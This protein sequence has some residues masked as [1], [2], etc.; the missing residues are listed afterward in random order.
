[1]QTRT[2]LQ[3]FLAGEWPAARKYP[4]LDRVLLAIAEGGIRINAEVRVAGLHDIRGAT[5]ETNVQGEIVQKLDALG[6][7][8]FVDVLRTC[9]R[10]AA[11]ACE[12]I[13][14]A[15]IVSDGPDAQ[16][17]AVFD[18]IDGS[19]NIDVAV[20]IGSIFGIYQRS[21]DVSAEALLRPGREQIC[22]LYIVYGSSTILALAAEGEVDAFTLDEH[23]GE[24]VLTDRNMKLP[25]ECPYYSV[26]EGNFD[27]W[28]PE[29]RE[30]VAELRSQYSLRYVGSL[31]SDF[32]RTLLKGGVFLY[33]ADKKSPDGKLRLLYEANPMAFLIE[34]AG[35]AAS[36]G[37]QRIMDIE[38]T[39][40]H[41]RTPLII[42][43]TEAVRLV[44]RH[45]Q[46][47]T[48]PA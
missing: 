46:R 5:G 2:S 42:G 33:P 39:K 24:F 10:V 45:L 15:V 32:H 41:Q 6:T 26:N 48:S 17:Y 22:A 36:N 35:G 8:T 38:L 12:E 28:A 21:G 4:G 7:E 31:V 44:E 13:G 47:L 27:R 29:M 11:L 19:S 9:G 20:P 37:A 23:S 34:Q 16:Y 14:D 1:M 25:A 3:T 40:L 43:T 18:P 30:A